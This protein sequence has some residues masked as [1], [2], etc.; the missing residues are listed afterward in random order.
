MSNSTETLVTPLSPNSAED[1]RLA[2][3]TWELEKV[4]PAQ[5]RMAVAIVGGLTLMVTATLL[6]ML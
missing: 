1:P 2:R 4:T 3:P 6:S 5:K